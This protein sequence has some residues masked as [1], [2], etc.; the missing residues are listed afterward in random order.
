MSILTSFVIKTTEFE[1]SKINELIQQ[2]EKEINNTDNDDQKKYLIDQKID[3]L[4]S[5][6]IN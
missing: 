4:K 1:K 2:A 6:S 5:I 3:I